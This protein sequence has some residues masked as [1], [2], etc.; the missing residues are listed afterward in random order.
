M[1]WNEVIRWREVW[2][3]KQDF[4]YM[5]SPLHKKKLTEYKFFFE[6]PSLYA[7]IECDN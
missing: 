2:C 6:I 5:Q 4:G 7:V 1:Q 3:F